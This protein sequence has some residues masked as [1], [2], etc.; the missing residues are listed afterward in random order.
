MHSC[1]LVVGIS[2]DMTLSPD[3]LYKAHV[4]NLR[5]VNSGI[6]HVE[7]ELRAAIATEDERSAETLLKLLLLLTGAWAE[8]RLRKLQY[9]PAGFDDNDRPAISSGRSQLE[10]WQ[11][12]LEVGYSKRYS[13]RRAQLSQE[14]L[15]ATA[16]LRFCSILDLVQTELKP[17]IEMRNTLAHGQWA[18]PLNSDENDISGAMLTSINAENALSVRFKLYLL[19]AISDLIHDLVSTQGAFERDYDDRFKKIVE[20]RRNLKNRSYERWRQS[21]IEKYRKGQEMRRK[22]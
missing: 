18:R 7:R 1:L 16:W 12:A 10:R 6:L 19:E 4:L 2:E 20:T 15:S 13:V 22:A 21:M 3:K 11:A 5:A 8:C 9:E 14:T 17:V